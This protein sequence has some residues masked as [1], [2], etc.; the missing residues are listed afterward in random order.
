MNLINDV[1]YSRL[2]HASGKTIPNSKKLTRIHVHS[3]A[4][5]AIMVEQNS[6]WRRSKAAA[7]KASLTANRHVCGN[8]NIDVGKSRLILDNSFAVSTKP[9]SRR[10]NVTDN[11]PVS[12]WDEQISLTNGEISDVHICVAPVL[13]CTEVKHTAGGGDNISSAGLVLQI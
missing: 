3:L 10:I 6:N 7:A 1:I 13:V 9:G 12:C 5:Q 2:I 11:K 4:Y 8:K